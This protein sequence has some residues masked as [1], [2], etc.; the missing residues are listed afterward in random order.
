MY[1]IVTIISI[2]IS[3]KN[4]REGDNN[5]DE[6]MIQTIATTLNVTPEKVKGVALD[7]LEEN[8]E[9][10]AKAGKDEAMMG[11]QALRI[12]QIKINRANAS[13]L[14]S[15]AENFV[16]MFVSVPRPKEWGKILYNKMNKDLL[17]LSDE[18]ING[19]LRMGNVVLYETVGNEYIRKANPALF[20][21]TVLGDDIEEA[22]VSDLPKE[23]KE[24]AEGKFFYI[25]WDNK[26]PTWPSGDRN[27]KFGRP[28]PQDERERVALFLGRKETEK[29]DLRLI[30][31]RANGK[32]ADNLYPPTFV[33]G[34]IPLKGARNPD[35]AYAVRDLSVFDGDASVQSMFSGP[36]FALED[37]NPIGPIT[38]LVREITSVNGLETYH[39]QNEGS[40]GWYDA[41]VG[42]V[43]EV[44]HMEPRDNGAMLLILGDEDMTSIDTVDVWVSGKHAETID[45]GVGSKVI[46]LGQTWRGREGDV[47]FSCSGWFA[48]ETVEA[49]DSD[50]VSMDDETGEDW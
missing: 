13:L 28:R 3:P 33:A 48:Y 49:M 27:F 24:Y 36:P 15:G 26:T 1:G 38:D 20:N 17:N 14:R 29:G 9:V 8:R 39:K 40:D 45:F 18:A 7:T 35:V 25:V 31:V 22:T 30:T 12:A 5:M 43:G 47:R 41:L 21:G 16:G 44:I 4:T 23:A 19:L 6:K 10:W 34:R 50:F 11:V 37:G 42:V 2:K 46:A 32:E